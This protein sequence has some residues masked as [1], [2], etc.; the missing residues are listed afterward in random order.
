MRIVRLEDLGPQGWPSPAITVGNFDG[1]HL[2]HRA[3]A[4]VAVGDAH[5]LAGTAVVLTF[6]PHP[7]RVLSPDRGPS[8]LMTLDQKARALSAL[9]VDV[10]AVL[11]FTRAIAER[12][13]ESFV[14]DVLHGALGARLVVVGENFRFGKG[15]RGDVSLL[16]RLGDELGFRVEAVA[17]VLQEGAPIS[18]T[19]IR[20]ALARGDVEAAGVLLGRPYSLEGT[21][22]RG[23]GRGRTLGIPTANLDSENETIPGRA[24]YAGLATVVGDEETFRAVVNVGRRPTFGGGE[25]TVEAHLLE[26]DRNLYGGRLRLA[27]HQRLREE[28][29]F[30]GPAELLTQIHEDIAQARALLG[31][32]TKAGS[33]GP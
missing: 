21:V 15:R 4:A 30:P 2:G 33:K 16:R 29:R 10:L 17:P 22:I 19:R 26:C 28:R 25:T 1:V 27:F 12:T 32:V 9:G 13:A 18:S 24:V 8:A 31:A 7:A 5:Q 20:E 14:S 23:D 6:D 11:P 3:L